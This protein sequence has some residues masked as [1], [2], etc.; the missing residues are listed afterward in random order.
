MPAGGRGPPSLFHSSEALFSVS[1]M[2]RPSGGGEGA[3][4]RALRLAFVAAAAGQE[5][6][7]GHDEDQ[8][9]QR[10]GATA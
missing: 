9:R 5:E 3:A 8:R 2:A 7:R 10:G 1:P 6:Q 4:G